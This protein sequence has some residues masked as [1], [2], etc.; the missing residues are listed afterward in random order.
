[1]DAHARLETLSTLETGAGRSL[2]PRGEPVFVDLND[3]VGRA[4]EALPASERGVTG[5]KA[6]PIAEESRFLCLPDPAIAAVRADEGALIR[7]ASALMQAMVRGAAPSADF[8]PAV[9]ISTFGQVDEV[10]LEIGR[11][12]REIAP[13]LF[14]VD[15]WV[16]DLVG[17]LGGRLDRFWSPGETRLVLCLPAA[18]WQEVTGRVALLEDEPAVRDVI[19]RLVGRL[20]LTVSAASS[21]GEMRDLI[22]ASPADPERRPA[23]LI[24]ETS[25]PAGPSG[26]AAERILRDHPD[27]AERMVLL[28]STPWADEVSR[29]LALLRRHWYLA[30]PFE[31]EAL[32]ALVRRRLMCLQQP[33]PAPP[34]EAG[35]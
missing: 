5:R 19:G 26:S 6:G 13:V 22:E 1:M 17:G 4:L 28:T 21:F 8:A 3:V 9:E 27:L 29:L 16:D 12:G 30:K 15:R 25:V 10:H 32:L 34:D 14:P 2:P 23:L 35:R 11:L 7:L 33:R 20:G 24:I 31:P 18:P